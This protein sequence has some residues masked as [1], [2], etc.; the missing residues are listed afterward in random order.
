MKSRT[1]ALDVQ[2]RVALDS[3]GG[4]QGNYMSEATK[5][6]DLESRPLMKRG[7]D[8]EYEETRGKDNR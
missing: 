1:D 4:K 6:V 7:E 5:A 8:G 2:V 3:T